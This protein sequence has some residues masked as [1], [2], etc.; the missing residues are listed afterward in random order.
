MSADTPGTRIRVTLPLRSIRCSNRCHFELRVI[1]QQL[2]KALAHH[3]GGTQN[4]NT[5]FFSHEFSLLVFGF[6]PVSSV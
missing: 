5:K 2:N 6:T 1:L 3:P 4:S